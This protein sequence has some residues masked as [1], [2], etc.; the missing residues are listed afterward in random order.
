MGLKSDLDFLRNVS[1]G[2]IASARVIKDLAASGL[3]PIE[4]ERSCTSNKMWKTR[5]RGQRVPDLLCVKT[6]IRFEVRGK[7]ALCIRMSDSPNRPERSWDAGLRGQDIV[8]IVQIAEQGEEMT[9]AEKPNYFR[10]EEGACS[11]LRILARMALHSPQCERSGDGGHGSLH[12][13]EVGRRDLAQVPLEWAASVRQQR[14]F[15]HRRADHHR[16]HRRP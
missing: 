4:L 13:G 16:R 10:V 15:L 7:G 14:R 11:G 8:A 2:A 1:M 3:S 12:R 9:A 5:F 6:G